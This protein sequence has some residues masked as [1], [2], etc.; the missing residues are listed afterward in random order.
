MTYT[1]CCKTQPLCY[2][3]TECTSKLLYYASTSLPYSA[4]T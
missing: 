1:G 3:E 2:L 4:P